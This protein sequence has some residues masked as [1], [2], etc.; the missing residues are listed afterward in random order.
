MVSRFFDPLRADA[1]RPATD[2]SQGPCAMGP[3]E[4]GAE[5]TSLH[6]WVFQ[7]GDGQRAGATGR[8]GVHVLDGD[9]EPPFRKRW[10]VRT[11]L[12]PGSDAFSGEHDATAVAMAF[13]RLP[14]GSTAVEHWTQ[15]V[16]I[17]V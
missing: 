12:E 3:I 1:D 14:D 7:Q 2:F 11:E 16:S 9:A 8:S 4:P 10:M 13:V 15:T 5:M 17:S 6:V